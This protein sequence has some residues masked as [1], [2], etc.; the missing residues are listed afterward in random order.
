MVMK[1]MSMRGGSMKRKGL[2]S[3]KKLGMSIT[4]R[5][6]K[7]ELAQCPPNLCTFCCTTHSF[8]LTDDKFHGGKDEIQSKP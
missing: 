5:L 2:L 3:N 8:M 4:P 7:I 6:L 1:M